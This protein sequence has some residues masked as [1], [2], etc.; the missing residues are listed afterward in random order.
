MSIIKDIL[1]E[2]LKRLEEL[3]VFYKDKLSEGPRGSISVKERGGKRYIYLARREG[4]KVVF[5]YVGKD[6]PKVRNAL[7]ER[8]SQQ[9]MYHVKLRQV[10]ENLRE[11]KRSLHGK[12]T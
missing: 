1:E 5:D 11:V 3:S 9:K 2:E 10:K 12:R 6:I 7:N 4:K 8:L